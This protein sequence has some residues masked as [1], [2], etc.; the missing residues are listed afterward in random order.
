MLT[1]AVYTPPKMVKTPNPRLVDEDTTFPTN[2]RNSEK[3]WQV[4]A[5]VES[6]AGGGGID[7]DILLKKKGMAKS[8]AVSDDLLIKCIMSLVLMVGR[9]TTQR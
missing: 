8:F 2:L 4:V 1:L 6:D 3:C 9:N 5:Q 7:A